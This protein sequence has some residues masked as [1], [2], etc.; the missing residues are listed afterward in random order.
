[1]SASSSS[2]SSSFSSVKLSSGL[3]SQ[4][5][6]A[7]SPM[8]RSVAGQIEYWA[9]LGRIAEASGLTVTEAREAIALYDVHQAAPA[10]ADPLDALEADFL[11]MVRPLIWQQHRRLALPLDLGALNIARARDTGIPSLNEARAQFFEQTGDTFIKPYTSWT[12][13]AANLKNPVSII[14]FVAAYGEHPTILAAVTMEE[15]RGAACALVFG[16]VDAPADRLDYLN[17]TGF[18]AANETGLNKVDFWIGGLAEASADGATAIGGGALAIGP[19]STSLGRGAAS[20]G[21]ASVAVGDMVE[22]IDRVSAHA[23]ESAK[24]AERSVAIANKGNEVVHNTIHGMDNIREQIQDTAKRIKRLGESSQ[25]IGDI[26]SLIDDIADQTNILALNAAIQ[27]SMAGDAG[28]GRRHGKQSADHH[29][30]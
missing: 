25:E 5:R 14:N 28:R 6:E 16:G 26:V 20:A 24:V 13:F 10:D 29:R 22:S 9:T 8:R 1:M 2:S 7:A 4:A 21:E 27:A 30:E 17:S 15:K 12:D 19:G 23:Y 3:V 11:A 18:W